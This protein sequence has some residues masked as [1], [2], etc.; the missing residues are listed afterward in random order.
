MKDVAGKLQ[1]TAVSK[2]L[3]LLLPQSSEALSCGC[4]QRHM[5]SSMY[6]GKHVTLHIWVTPETGLTCHPLARYIIC[7]TP[8]DWVHEMLGMIDCFVDV[9][10]SV[11]MV[12][13]SS[14]M[15]FHV[16]FV[17]ETALCQFTLLTIH[18]NLQEAE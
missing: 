5:Y 16:Y 13:S 12:V 1:T 9:A 15:S 8:A 2:T 14:E 17:K 10:Q 6:D 11:P 3:Y 4:L 18:Q 7:V